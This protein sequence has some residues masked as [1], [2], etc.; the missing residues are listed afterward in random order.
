MKGNSS[1]T[2]EF[3]NRARAGKRNENVKSKSLDV[4]KK[5]SLRSRVIYVVSPPSL[6]HAKRNWRGSKRWDLRCSGAQWQGDENMLGIIAAV[7]ILFW[8]LG[9]F[10]FQVTT[11]LIHVALIAGII[12]LVMHFMR[13]TTASA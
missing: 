6:L 13:R 5:T 4:Q 12:P 10:A 8:L 2:S 9:F 7:L 11:A 3:K 1:G